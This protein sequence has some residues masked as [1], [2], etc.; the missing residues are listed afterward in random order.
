MFLTVLKHEGEN[1]GHVLLQSQN[2]ARDQTHKTTEG[3]KS[4]FASRP[5]PLA[6]LHQ[7]YILQ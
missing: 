3:I 1:S 5:A 6:L 4:L 2:K 7:V